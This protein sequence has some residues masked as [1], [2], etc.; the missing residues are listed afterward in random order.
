M[1]RLF[2]LFFLSF[3]IVAA[4]AQTRPAGSNYDY[5]TLFSPLFYTHNGN[6]Y[7]A[8]NGEPGPA[9]WQ[10]QAD[11]NIDVKLDDSKSEV[12]ASLLLTYK[13]NSPQQLPYIWFQLDQ[14]LFNDSSRGQA[15][16]PAM[17]SSRYGDAGSAFKGGFSIK[18]VKLVNGQAES[19][20]EYL[21]SDTRMQVRLARPVAAKGGEL[22]LKIDFSFIIPQYGADR[23]GIL[24]TKNG[25]IFSVAQWYPRV[26]VYDDIRGWNTDPYLGAS[27]FYLEYGDFDVSITAPAGLIVVGSGELQNPADVLTPQQL[28]RYNQAKESDKTVMIRSKSE[29]TDAKSRPQKPSLTWKFRI[30]NARDFAWAASKAFI[31]DAARINLPGGK[32]GL[33]MSVYPVESDGKEAWGRS[34]EYTKASMENYSKR[35]FEYPYYSAVNVASNVG[36]M[37]Y[38][39]I[40]FCGAGAKNSGLWGVTDHE[41]GHTWFPMI[42]GSNEKRYGW[43]DEGFNTF[44]NNISS[45][46]FN[47]GEYKAAKRDAHQI[48]YMFGPLSESVYNTPDGMKERSIGN[49]LYFKPG[50]ALGLLRDHI[51]G[52]DRFDYAFRKYISDWAYKHPTPWD[53]FRSMENGAGE[54]LAWFWRGVFLNSYALDQVVR[55]VEYIN[56]DPK[57]G[58]LITIENTEPLAMPVIVEYTTTSGKT[59]R[60]TLPVEIWQNNNTWTFKV[61]TNEELTKVV[62]DPDHVFPDANSANNT[63]QK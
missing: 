29:V 16:L 44:I 10:N 5:H 2:I 58:A 28:Q 31:W 37:E 18:A 63:W 14:N 19:D 62:L 57:N 39:G 22:K 61:D 6:E 46:D 20:A 21:V 32:K 3:V 49:L 47:N 36:G 4:F 23:T 25:N 9:Y 38:P 40:V 7:R 1:K 43:M 53:F 26:C 33:A 54:D 55:K 35:W 15:K 41:F 60:K 24:R 52:P 50:Y 56:G 13:N 30:S 59:A 17:G 8:A 11:Y 48:A 27:E 42:V 51:L 45:G 34:T 12:S